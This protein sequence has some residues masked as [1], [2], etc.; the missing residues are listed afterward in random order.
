M[1]S[2][3]PGQGQL[4]GAGPSGG[5]AHVQRVHNHMCSMYV[6]HMCR[7]HFADVLMLTFMFVLRKLWHQHVA[8]RGCRGA[9]LVL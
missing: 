2:D 7:T 6:Y 5:I 8:C 3:N 9:L 4:R 1:T